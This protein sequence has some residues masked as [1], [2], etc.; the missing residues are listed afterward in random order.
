MLNE[1]SYFFKDL[2]DSK[3][4]REEEERNKEIIDR[5]VR[6]VV[7]DLGEAW[8]KL[9]GVKRS[10]KNIPCLFIQDRE[11]VKKTILLMYDIA[12]SLRVP[13]DTKKFAKS[14][15]F[16]ESYYVY[17]EEA[18]DRRGYSPCHIKDMEAFYDII[19]YWENYIKT[20]NS[21]EDKYK[22]ANTEFLEDLYEET[23]NIFSELIENKKE[24]DKRKLKTKVEKAVTGLNNLSKVSS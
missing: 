18:F 17:V 14:Q 6:F 5:K 13:L 7:K 3:K 2:K 16:P 20:V 10:L 23:K 12:D 11:I 8:F 19:K 9:K 21:L 15:G 1:L 4:K 22:G 24:E